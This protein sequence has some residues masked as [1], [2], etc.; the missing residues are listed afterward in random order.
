M[1]TL[2]IARPAAAI[3]PGAATGLAVRFL[4]WI[5]AL[6]AGY[7]SAHALAH[8]TD[9]RLADMGL[10]RGAA[11]AEFARHTGSVTPPAAIAW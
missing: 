1:T 11:E 2:Q 4:A 8:A 3:A 5:V 10:T 7:R 9:D 6:D